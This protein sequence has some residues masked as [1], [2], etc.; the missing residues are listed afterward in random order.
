MISTNMSMFNARK[1]LFVEVVFVPV[2][3]VDLHTPQL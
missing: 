2:C 1:M 3:L